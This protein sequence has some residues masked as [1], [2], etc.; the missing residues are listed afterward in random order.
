MP[1]P[2]GVFG[3][4]LGKGRAPAAGAWAPSWPLSSRGRLQNPSPPDAASTGSV[5]AGGRVTRLRVAMVGETI[6]ADPAVDP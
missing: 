3:D 1:W 5:L 4:A 2:C 6:L